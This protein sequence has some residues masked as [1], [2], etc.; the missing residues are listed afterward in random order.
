M[1]QPKRKGGRPKG[2]KNKSTL[3]AAA[4]AQHGVTPLETHLDHQRYW[5]N[6]ADAERAKP[7][8]EQ[9]EKRLNDAMGKEAQAAR[10]SL[11]YLHGRRA[12]EAAPTSEVRPS[13]IYGVKVAK[14]SKTWLAQS[15]P[16]SACIEQGITPIVV[17]G[18]QRMKPLLDAEFAKH[19]KADKDGKLVPITEAAK[20]E[21]TKL[22]IEIEKKRKAVDEAIRRARGTWEPGDPIQ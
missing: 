15:A 3:A 20:P 8:G 14:D 18:D 16:I 11:P 22:E 4:L 21:P 19:G 13:V 7:P 9:N 17:A 2:S 6:I 1:D 10:D 5:K 12:T